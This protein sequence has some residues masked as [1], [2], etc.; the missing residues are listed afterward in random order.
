MENQ[1]TNKTCT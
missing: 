1:S